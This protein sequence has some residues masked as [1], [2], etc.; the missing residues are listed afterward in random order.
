M[1]SLIRSAAAISLVLTAQA[2]AGAPAIEDAATHDTRTGPAPNA[3]VRALQDQAATLSD[4]AV[5][6][7]ATQGAVSAKKSGGYAPLPHG[8]AMTA[9]NLV[10]VIARMA[11]TFQSRQDMLPHHVAQVTALGMAPDSLGERTGI[12][13]SIGH[14]RY[15]FAAWKRYERH[16]GHSVE[17]TIRPSAACEIPF[18]SLRD[19]LVAAG[20]AVS[21]NAVGFKPM[22]YFSRT[23]SDGLDLHIILNT[24][25]HSQPRCVS[26]VRLEME[27][28]DG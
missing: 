9:D 12:H 1:H 28:G 16:P 25:S 4:A 5:D 7:A 22:V 24:D 2:C 23:V 20:F 21:T 10:A 27:P 17:L 19:P 14:A 8:P 13:G 6:E 18:A 15:E 11:S 26:R 3:T